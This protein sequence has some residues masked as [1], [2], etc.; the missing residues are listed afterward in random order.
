MTSTT[1]YYV[2]LHLSIYTVFVLVNEFT[3]QSG[4]VISFQAQG[5]PARRRLLISLKL[6]F[7]F[8]ILYASIILTT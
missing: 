6:E 2:L 4:A 3:A 1:T 7:P 8:I 5:S